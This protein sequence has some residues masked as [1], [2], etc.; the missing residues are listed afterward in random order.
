MANKGNKGHIKRLNAPKYFAIHR[1]EHAY[2][3]KQNPGRHS[4]EKSVALTVLVEKLGLASNRK[5]SNRIINEGMVS[6]NGRKIT[7]AK[8]PVGLHDVLA[9]GSEKHM[10]G[11]NNKGQVYFKK[12][13]KGAQVYKVVGRVQIQEWYCHAAPT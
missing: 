11:I 2:T 3:T 1:K 7:D 5:D 12:S 8:Y 6:V 9:A 4:L 13:E 10:V